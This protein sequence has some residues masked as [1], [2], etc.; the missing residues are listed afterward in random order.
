[1]F[2]FEITKEDVKNSLESNF[3]DVE[4]G[5]DTINNLYDELDF[6]AIEKSVMYET[7]FDKQTEAAFEEIDR[8]IIEIRRKKCEYGWVVEA[9]DCK[10]G[11]KG[12]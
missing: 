10:S 3:P 11:L 5:D 4:S 9:P 1:M 8:Q 7:D 6:D 2:A 12:A